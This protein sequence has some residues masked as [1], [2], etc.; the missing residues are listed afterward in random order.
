MSIEDIISKDYSREPV[1]VADNRSMW[2]LIAVYVAMTVCISALILGAQIGINSSVQDT[3]IGSVLGGLLLSFVGVLMAHIG[4]DTKLSL[5]MISNFTF[6]KEGSKIIS[7]ILVLTLFGW[8]GVQTEVFASS[9]SNLMKDVFNINFPRLAYIFFGGLLM[10]STAIIG[11]KALEKLSI[12]AVPLLLILI[13]L[14]FVNIYNSNGL[15]NILSYQSQNVMSLASIISLVGGSFIVGALI[16]PDIMRYA[17]TN[18]DARFAT[19]FSFSIFYPIFLTLTA[20]IA[21][22]VNELDVIKMFLMV[23]LG[24][25]ALIILIVASWTTN[26][27]NL[28]SSSLGLSVIFKSY[29]KPVLASIAGAIGT[30]CAAM[31]ILNYF[32]PWLIFLGLIIAPVGGVI[33]AD[34]FIDA[35]AYSFKK[36][37][38]VIKFRLYNLIAWI[39]GV[40]GG[41]MTTPKSSNGL[42]LFELTSISSLDGILISACLVLLYNRIFKK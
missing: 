32:I 17:K 24:V 7:F 21:I 25:P 9:L 39:F 15:Q 31:G 36:L 6:G 22:Y 12:I 28:Y 35:K 19:F 40:L 37:E 38:S 18:R 26:D 11:F 30:V 3:I 27:S 33:I 10:S 34:Y 42:G 29:S 1:L 23:G 5:A 4:S 41:I 20:V 14:P 8:F 16:T 2:S 13:L